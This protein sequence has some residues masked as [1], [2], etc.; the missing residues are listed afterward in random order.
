MSNPKAPTGL[1]GPGRRFWKAATRERVFSESHDLAR[2]LI[3][4]RTLDEIAADEAT[5]A[6]EGRFTVDRWGRRVAHPALK[7][8]QEN[9]ALFLRVI[10]ELALDLV[11]PE[12]SRPPRQY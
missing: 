3:G 12:D 8:L 1:R 4:A 11:A 6:T 10:R 7:S 9:R 5:L 2:L